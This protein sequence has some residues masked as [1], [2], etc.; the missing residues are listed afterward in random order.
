[1]STVMTIKIKEQDIKIR[2]SFAPTT[3]V[4]K[5]KKVYNRKKLEKIDY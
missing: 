5:S 1:M 2:K 3:K 4:V